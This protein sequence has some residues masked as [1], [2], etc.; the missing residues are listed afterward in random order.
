MRI[1]V[2][3]RRHPGAVYPPGRPRSTISEGVGSRPATL[4]GRATI[5]VTGAT[6]T[7]GRE[8]VRLLRAHGDPVR[9][10]VTAPETART[11]RGAGVEV[12]RFERPETYAPAL[13]G[14]RA[15]FLM[16]PPAMVDARQGINPFSDAAVAAGVERVVF[17]S[18]LG[19][20][21]NPL[22][23]HAAIERHLRR[24]GAGWTF[25][26]PS[27]FMQN[28]SGVH[29][30]DIRRR[31][32]IVVPAGRGR[33]S[34]IDVR[35]I[36]AVAVRTRTEPG[37]TGQ[38]YPLT[39]GE[40]LTYFQVARIL[41]LALGRRIRYTRPSL[42]GYVR[43]MLRDGHPLGFALVTAAIYTV[44]RLGLAATV[45]DDVRRLLGR[46]PTTMQQ[47]VRDERDCWM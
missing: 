4:G 41:S 20:D 2:L 8:V 42:A 32:E 44:A 27:Y 7:V 30:D 16:R 40:A 3:T 38:A 36:A 46:P 23:P 26:R 6:G 29:R 37:H 14:V 18:L 12:V 34:F 31:N 43:H 15:L 35:D 22:V 39:G 25:L 28:L 45:T 19:A 9:A 33:T 17:L 1:D 10:A 11:E 13:A 24:T 5:L 47:F 21:R